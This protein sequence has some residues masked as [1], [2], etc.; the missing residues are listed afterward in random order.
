MV[1]CP[2]QEHSIAELCECYVD[3]KKARTVGGRERKGRN[4]YC[5][6]VHGGTQL[7]MGID[8]AGILRTQ[9]GSDSYG[10]FQA[11]VLTT[12]IY[13]GVVVH[14]LMESLM[15]CVRRNVCNIDNHDAGVTIGL[16][17]M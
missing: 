5:R 17:A 10:K 15:E 7:W 13:D 12:K 14:S 4:E 2:K 3:T 8:L 6:A 16:A 1:G 9:R 11:V